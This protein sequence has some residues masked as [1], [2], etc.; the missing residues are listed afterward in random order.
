MA[1]TATAAPAQT[2]ERTPR[3]TA[4][5]GSSGGIPV[6]V[7]GAV[8]AGAGNRAVARLV[9]RDGPTPPPSAA[10]PTPDEVKFFESPIEN[11]VGMIGKKKSIKSQLKWPMERAVW[12]DWVIL[13]GFSVT[14]EAG[15]EIA[16]AGNTT[17]LSLQQGGAQSATR[18]QRKSE[19]EGRGK[20][21][22]AE[23]KTT[24][25]GI[26][27][28]IRGKAGAI[29][30]EALEVKW[31]GLEGMIGNDEKG[32]ER[33]DEVGLG[34]EVT[35]KIEI[36]LFDKVKFTPSVSLGVG[37]VGADMKS[38]PPKVKVGAASLNAAGEVA[39]K[40]SLSPLD[41]AGLRTPRYDKAWTVKVTGSAH[42]RL[43]EK[44]IA[45]KL[46]EKIA[47]VVA[48]QAAKRALPAVVRSL[49]M[50]DG[51]EAKMITIAVLMVCNGI[52][53]FIEG[54][55]QKN[56][57]ELAASLPYV[58]AGGFMSTYKKM[59]VSAPATA[60]GPVAQFQE[61]GSGAGTKARA[62]V[63]EEVKKHPDAKGHTDAEITTE[64]DAAIK[65][66]P[67]GMAQVAAEARKQVD[68]YVLKKFIDT[69]TNAAT[70]I[71]DF[72]AG[73]DH[74]IDPNNP[75]SS[76]EYVH[77]RDKV[78]KAYTTR[79]NDPYFQDTALKN[80][81]AKAQQEGVQPD[82]LEAWLANYM[83]KQAQG[84]IDAA[85][86]DTRGDELEGKKKAINDLLS[87]YVSDEDIRNVQPIVL[88][89]PKDKGRDELIAVCWKW[90]F[91]LNERQAKLLSDLTG[92]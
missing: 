23:L 17:V 18:E 82:Q 53:A 43:N 75:E 47:V 31:L 52:D 86:P 26:L 25:D 34:A 30:G 15:L 92:A 56:L 1:E 11:L 7:V 88:G 91:H 72:M 89:T 80:A 55:R 24:H 6:G 9:Q 81:M 36:P 76:P 40:E 12:K 33:F 83:Q 4:A 87:G 77:F 63:I 68:D 21:I 54:D 67:Y 78:L 84:A 39:H 45:Q 85:E 20:T 32:N 73:T 57:G 44:K 38:S 2:A 8:Q 79:T 50:L 42:A 10:P 46:A 19:L 61:A 66:K 16:R 28:Q 22:G 74:K 60:Y 70:D 65:E 13:E 5:E 3:S 41:I 29:Q 62:A 69:R 14:A 49:K 27:T 48:E 90:K 59:P 51:P 58:F 71:F 64:V 37:L 35:E